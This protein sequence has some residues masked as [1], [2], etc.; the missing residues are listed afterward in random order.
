MSAPVT[1]RE[2]ARLEGC[3]EKQVRRGIADGK[4]IA[5]ARGMLDPAQVRSGWRQSRGNARE[6]PAG[7]A[8]ISADNA[9]NVRKKPDIRPRNVRIAPTVPSPVEAALNQIGI[10]AFAISAAKREH[11][12]AMQRQLE[13]DQA[14]G[15]VVLVSEV[16]EQVGA[17][18]ASVR[19]RLLALPA[20][21]AARLTMIRAPAEM[22]G[23]LYRLITEA[24]AGLV[25][26]QGP[27][28]KNPTPTSG[29]ARE[30][31]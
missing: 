8:D 31:T 21:H 27:G 10:P 15:K 13:Y 3:D 9:P 17:Q 20:E 19:T 22:Q 5:D 23:V 29:T 4:L 18:L 26:D 12:A 1:R 30:E 11:Y 16:A 6:A 14:V 28:S 2:F 25:A 24:L 7:H